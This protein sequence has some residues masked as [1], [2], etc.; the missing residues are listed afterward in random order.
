MREKC[1]R[2]QQTRSSTNTRED[3]HDNRIMVQVK[4]QQDD[5]I[6]RIIKENNE[7]I[8]HTFEK[9][10]SR[11]KSLEGDKEFTK[12]KENQEWNTERFEKM[13]SRLM[14]KIDQLATKF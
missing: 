7:W 9:M 1:G 11:F 8:T 13:E 12:G 6:L 5:K 10:E 2:V 4:S 14:Q 3:S